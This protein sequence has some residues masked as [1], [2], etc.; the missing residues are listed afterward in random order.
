MDTPESQFDYITDLSLGYWKSQT[1]M[2]GVEFGI[3]TLLYKKELTALKVSQLIKTDERATELLLNSLVGLEFLKKKKNLYINMPIANNFLVEERPLY[4]GNRIQLSKNLWANWTNLRKAIKNGKPAFENAKRKA[5]PKR[6]EVFISAMNDFA[7]FKSK[8]VAE[9][10]DLS[11]RQRLLDLGGGPGSYAIEFANANPDLNAV[12]FDMREVTK[13]TKRYIKK[14]KMEKRVSTRV[15]E[16]LSDGYGEDLYD[17]VFLSNLLHMYDEGVNMGVLEKC[18]KA[19]KPNGLIIIHDF[20][21]DASL[22]SS[23]FSALFSLNMLL[24][25]HGGRNYSVKEYEV[26]LKKIGFTKCSKVELDEDSTLIKAV[27]P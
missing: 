23:T 17:V 7:T 5:A 19:L 22:T 27:K 13:I 24:G 20:M 9:K 26:W 1:L 21:L 14:A 10:I 11:G 4:Q 16:C 2:V 15:G 18:K 6:R 25:T 8:I 3:F 12:V